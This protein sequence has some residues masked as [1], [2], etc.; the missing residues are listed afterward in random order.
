MKLCHSVMS[1]LG[2]LALAAVPSRG[3]PPSP[4]EPVVGPEWKPVEESIALPTGGKAHAT[5]HFNRNAL[6]DACITDAGLLAV[7]DS[8]N[9]LRFDS[10]DLR[11]QH[12]IRP[13]AAITLLTGVNGVGALAA[14]ADGRVFRIDPMTLRQTEFA[15]L[16]AAPRWMAGFRDAAKANNGVLAVVV[17]S[18]GDEVEL[19][20]LGIERPSSEKHK[21]PVPLIRRGG[22]SA[23][24]L[25]A[26]SRL[27]LG[28]D[29]GEWGGWCGSLDLSAGKA[30]K[31]EALKD[32]YLSGVYGFVEL[33]DG[34]VWAY[35]GTMH[36][37]LSSG[38]IARID[39]GKAE[40]LRSFRMDRAAKPNAPPKEPRYPITHVM[41]DPK[42]DGL[43]VFAYRDLFRVDAGLTNWRHLG[44]IELRYR[45]GRPDAMG[46]YPALRTVLDA[47]DKSG[48]LICSTAR[49]GLL[50]IREGRVT[51]Y[52]V[53]GQ[54]GD[55][56]ID[57]ILPASGTTLLGGED[58]WRYTGGRWQA[59]S[60]FPP[61]KPGE[62]EDW[63]ERSLMLDPDRRPVALCRSDTTPGS[64]ALTRLKD[65]KVE[66]VAS[67]RGVGFSARGGFAT[68]DG[69]YW[70]AGREK[71]LRL[72]D[73]KWQPAGKAPERFLWGLRVVGQDQPPWTLHCE[74]GLYR[75]IPGTGAQDAGLT[76]IV[77]PAE[78]GKVHD[79]LALKTGQLLLACSAGLRLFDENSGKVSECPFV[80]PKGEVLALCRDGRGRTWLAGSSVWMVDGKGAVHDLG[81]LSRY[82]AVVHA[83]GADSTDT[84]GVI[85]ALGWRGVLF[86][87]AE[88]VGR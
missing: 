38:Y 79:V 32:S 13:G 23:F 52:V 82:G 56:R 48:D 5:Y 8:G 77:L 54:I 26:R 84:T 15:R 24:L 22:I 42:G 62:R 85:V 67:E 60:M 59:A 11:L 63:Y 55:D 87:R 43:L 73:G 78:L 36:L 44:T 65:G 7:T 86:V 46:S 75:L 9:L 34:Q 41:P 4:R 68:P 58:L 71:L 53:P 21:V 40:E 37:G 33:P 50:R 80:P 27:W 12:E 20:R 10:K 70:C 76:P 83:V 19:H 81:K 64:V 39:R 88:D 28:V 69:G 18:D 51:Q 45:L 72:V 17:S 57:T 1:F 30:G 35:G 16:P 47:G 29:A 6:S 25:D 74:G 61:A 31:V 14:A 2:M 66:V 3:E 49:D